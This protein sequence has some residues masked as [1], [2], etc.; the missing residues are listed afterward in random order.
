[1]EREF[2]REFAAVF[3]QAAQLHRLA[4]YPT[5]PGRAKSR[6]AFAVRFAISLRHEDGQRLAEHFVFAIAKNLL[7]SVVPGRDVPA[8][9]GQNDSVV[10][11]LN[12]GAEAILARSQRAL[13]PLTLDTM[14]ELNHHRG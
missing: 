1:R 7:R 10:C 2:E 11:R 9:I 12:E 6:D 14:T 8:L 4:N 3:A 13:Q 5:F